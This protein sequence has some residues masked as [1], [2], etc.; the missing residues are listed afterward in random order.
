MKYAVFLKKALMKNFTYIG[1]QSYI[2][3]GTV[4]DNLIMACP[5]SLRWSN[6]ARLGKVGLDGFLKEERGLDTVLKR[7]EQTFPAASGS[8]WH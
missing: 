7:T 5:G 6:V 8:D 3:K 2:F 4:R 1:H